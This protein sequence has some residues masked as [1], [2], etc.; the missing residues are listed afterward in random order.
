MITR[1]DLARIPKVEFHRHLDGSIRF[2]TLLDL[3]KENKLP[4]SY[5][6]D[7]LFLKA[8][9]TKPMKDLQKVLDSFWISQKVLC[10]YDA[11]KR[12]TF[13]NIED[14]YQD[15]IKLIEL[16]FAA[17]FIAFGKK[18]NNDEIIEAVIDGV[19]EGMAKFPVQVGLIHILPRSLGEKENIEAHQTILKYKKS[20]HKN[21]ERLVGFDLAD[22]EIENDRAYLTQIEEAKKAGLGIT[23][24]SGENTTHTCVMNSINNLHAQR[25][26]HGLKIWGHE[27]AIKL[28]KDRNIHFELCPTSN[29]LT[30]SVSS[31]KKHPFSALSKAGVSVSLNSDDPHLMGIDLLNEYR[32][33]HE[34]F[35]WSQEDFF[36]MNKKAIEHSFLAKDIVADVKK[37]FF[38]N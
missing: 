10:H 13:E 5:S 30:N 11:I 21:A 17:S 20:S 26:G 27:E 29:W 38:L 7:E 25:I 32:I 35:G 19:T 12:V 3:I 16:R 14:A 31:L 22:G 8:R 34:I 28:A 6:P 37:K 24:H 1:A 4:N 15:G 2:Q 33:V 9:V 23:I 18:L 36:L